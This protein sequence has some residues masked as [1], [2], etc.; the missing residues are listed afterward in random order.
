MSTFW[1]VGIVVN[2]TLTALAIYWL[3]SNRAKEDPKKNS[4][5]DPH[6]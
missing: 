6:A 3:W 5:S 4:R 1:L 2:V